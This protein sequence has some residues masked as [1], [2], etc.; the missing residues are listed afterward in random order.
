MVVRTTGI[1]RENGIELT[2]PLPD[3]PSGTPVSVVVTPAHVDDAERHRLIDALCGAWAEDSSLQ[4]I[5]DEL[6]TARA[7][8]A[9]RAADFDDPS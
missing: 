3:L 5:F 7:A 8:V 6:A 2:G 4:S 1:V 9:S